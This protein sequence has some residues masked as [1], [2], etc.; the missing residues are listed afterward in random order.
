M[1]I[2]FTNTVEDFAIFG[3]HLYRNNPVLRQQRLRSQVIA[4]VIY[5]GIFLISLVIFTAGTFTPLIITLAGLVLLV[6]EPLLF[7]LYGLYL[8][9]KY[10][11][12]T[13]AYMK[14]ELAHKA[15]EEVSLSFTDTGL[16]VVAPTSQ[17]QLQWAAITDIATL[18]H[19]LL[20]YISSNNAFV[21]PQRAF[22]NREHWAVFVDQ[23]YKVWRQNT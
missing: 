2:T 23:I 17:S 12:Q 6:G 7:F 4:S 20:I 10:Q 9:K 18:P 3:N 8:D 19:H 22:P 13:I 11:R 15:P 16:S 14:Q 5:G 21:I 1:D